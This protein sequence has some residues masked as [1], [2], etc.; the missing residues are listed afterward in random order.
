MIS[1]SWWLMMWCWRYIVKTDKNLA[2]HNLC[3]ARAFW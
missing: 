2:S 3:E 1:Q